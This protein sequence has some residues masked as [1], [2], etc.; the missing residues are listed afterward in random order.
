MSG[1]CQLGMTILNSDLKF[2]STKLKIINNYLFAIT[3]SNE[4]IVFIKKEDTVN[5]LNY[6]E[7]RYILLNNVQEREEIFDIFCLDSINNLTPIQKK[8]FSYCHKKFSCL[9]YQFRRWSLLK[10]DKFVHFR[11]FAG[12]PYFLYRRPIFG[13][14]FSKNYFFI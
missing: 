13:F 11:K 2:K 6:F 14:Y 3:D 7:K 9:L 1:E 5:N 8:N 12:A 4:I 10:Q